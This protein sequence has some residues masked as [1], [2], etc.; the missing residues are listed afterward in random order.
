MNDFGCRVLPLTTLALTA[1]L[2]MARPAPAVAANE[3]SSPY[4]PKPAALQAKVDFWKQIYTGY[5]VPVADVV[6]AFRI[7]D[8]TNV[9]I[10]NVPRNVLREILWTWIAAP[11]PRGPDIHPNATGYLAIAGAFVKAI[12]AL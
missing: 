4:F 3:A 6:G 1:L 11:P 8:W 12:G 2:L 7:D 5:G 9:P 10:L